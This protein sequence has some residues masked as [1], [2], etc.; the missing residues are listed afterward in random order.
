MENIS[1]VRSRQETKRWQGPLIDRRGITDIVKIK[2]T[3]EDKRPVPKPDKFSKP[4]SR[5]GK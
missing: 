4:E 3:K 2:L 5:D 1:K